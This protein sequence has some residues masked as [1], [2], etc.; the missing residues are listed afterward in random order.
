MWAHVGTCVRPRVRRGNGHIRRGGGAEVVPAGRG[1][2]R[3]R[4]RRR[5]EWSA[6]M[7]RAR[8]G[9]AARR[10][11]SRRR[12]CRPNRRCRHGRFHARIRLVSRHLRASSP[13]GHAPTCRGQHRVPAPQRL[14]VR[15]VLARRRAWPPRQS[16]GRALPAGRA[17]QSASAGWCSPKYSSMAAGPRLC[18]RR[19]RGTARPVQ[20]APRCVPAVSFLVRSSTMEVRLKPGPADVAPDFRSA[21]PSRRYS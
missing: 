2:P 13:H 19:G 1:R 10:A 18:R 11:R 9:T 7:A 15:H 12:C 4:V 14:P 17:R 21:V 3:E 20:C 5:R 6:A 8:A 16:P